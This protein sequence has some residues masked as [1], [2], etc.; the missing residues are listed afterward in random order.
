MVLVPGVAFSSSGTRLGHGS[1][2]YDEF[3][4]RCPGGVARVGVTPEALVVEALPF[5]DHD[6]AMTHLATESGVRPAR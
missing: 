2:Y 3:L 4:S 1:G 5:D 6:V